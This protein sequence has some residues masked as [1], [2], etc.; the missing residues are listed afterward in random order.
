MN[1]KLK[2]LFMTAVVLMT[3]QALMA[4]ET[5]FNGAEFEQLWKSE[6]ILGVSTVIE[7][8]PDGGQQG[9][10]MNDKFYVHLNYQGMIVSHDSNDFIA[11]W[12][13]PTDTDP[14]EGFIDASLS[15]DEAGNWIVRT[16]NKYYPLGSVDNEFLIIS[17]DGTQ[18]VYFDIPD[19]MCEYNSANN[20]MYL[21]TASGNLLSSEGGTLAF[22]G[23]RD[24]IYFLT[25]RN[26]AVVEG[27]SFKAGFNKVLGH[28]NDQLGY[29]EEIVVNA[30]RAADGTVHYLYVNRAANPIDMVLD[31]E[32]RVFNGK[33]IDVHR[34]MPGGTSGI[35]SRGQLNG[36]SMFSMGGKNY[37]VFPAIPNWLDAFNIIEVNL[38][39]AS[40]IQ[41]AYHKNDYPKTSTPYEYEI[42]IPCNWLNAEVIGDH[43]AYIYQYFP[44]GYMA[45]YQFVDKPDE[46]PLEYIV[47]DGEEDN[48]YT[49]AD[50]IIAVYIAEKEPKRLYAK[51]LGRHRFPSVKGADEVDYVRDRARLQTDV[52]D[53]SNWVLLDFNT[54]EEA[55]QFLRPS[56]GVIKGG[57]LTGELTDKLNPTMTVTSYQVPEQWTDYV[58][59]KHVTANYMDPLVQTGKSGGKYF[60]VEPKAQEYVMIYWAKYDGHERYHFRVPDDQENSN[61]DK[62]AGGFTVNWSLYP[63]NYLEDF[64]EGHTYNFHAIIRYTA[65]H[66]GVLGG[67][68]N[69][70][71]LRE[72]EGVSEG[73]YIVYPLEG[74]DE[75][76]TAIDELFS[77]VEPVEVTYV[78]M[79]GMKS[80]QPF[81]GVNIVVTRYN[82]GMTK[83]HKVIK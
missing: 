32:N 81:A 69:G 75:A 28:D 33:F 80:T 58:E 79:M 25:I 46:T 60:F 45:K 21:G 37:M 15:Y 31:K 24:G 20:M 49:I 47:N 35:Y 83:V 43:T 53:Q 76:M 67:G 73:D 65:D 72:G 5:G 40:F 39:D 57:T 71:P 22:A 17:A 29:H 3:A 74:G 48:T 8:W 30:W 2:M 14:D 68:P 44:W 52:W 51:D 9:F 38:E 78:N 82:N 66:H 7:D 16:R 62:L 70:A 55:R 13:I 6:N 27:E 61:I 42:S 26:G 77:D 36:Y 64:I 18:R 41:K 56:K 12:E 10:G 59:N 11:G 4:E 34:N 63:G 1:Q 54:E 23:G 50:D 19:G